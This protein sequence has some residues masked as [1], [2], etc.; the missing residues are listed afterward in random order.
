MEVTHQDIK[1]IK[2][3]VS[4]LSGKLTEVHTALIGSK[5]TGDGGLIRRVIDSE[6]EVERLTLRIAELENKSGKTE[7]YLKVIWGLGGTT[8]ASIFFYI[9]FYIL[10]LIFHNAK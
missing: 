1:Q 10:K 2:E 4:D 7:F 9:F 8:T 3:Q 5:I 6:A